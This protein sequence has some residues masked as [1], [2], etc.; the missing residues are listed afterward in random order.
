M[1]APRHCYRHP[2]RETR[3]SCAAC[4]KPICTECMIQT[5]VGIKCP[6]DARLPRGARAGVMKPR[7]I[8]KTAGAGAG[9]AL[10]GIAVVFLI[11][12]I[13]FGSLILSGVGG[14]GAG[15]LIYRASGYNGGPL[16]ISVSVAAVLISF[17]VYPLFLGY[18]FSTGLMLPALVAVVLAIIASRG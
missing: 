4:G 14:Y 12:Q 9:V 11:L 18:P 2:D 16:A 5:D 1:A 13:G 15:T 7:Q 3:V 10:A 17:A 6:D 8:A